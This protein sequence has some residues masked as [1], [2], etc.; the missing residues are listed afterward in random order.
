MRMRPLAG[1]DITPGQAV[2]LS[3]GGTHIMLQ[4]LTQPLREKQSFPLT[5]SFEHA[6]S[7]EVTVSVEKSGATRPAGQAAG[8]PSTHMHH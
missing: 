3:P 5:L 7:R 6:G 4:G 2:T 8:P 1:I